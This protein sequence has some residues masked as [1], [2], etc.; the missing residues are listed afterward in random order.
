M[1]DRIENRS[2]FL[3]LGGGWIALL[4]MAL[5]GCNGDGL[6][7]ADT[8]Q[9]VPETRPEADLTVL[10][11]SQPPA[12]VADSVS[13][14]AVKGKN[15]FAEM[16]FADSLGHPAD[17]LLRFY[18]DGKSLYRYPDGKKFGSKDSVLITIRVTDPRTLAFEFE[19]SGLQF[20]DKEPAI[21]TVN[22][23]R[24]VTQPGPVSRHDDDDDDDDDD[25]EDD[26]DQ[27]SVIEAD[28]ALWVQE[29]LAADY[30]R[31]TTLVDTTAKQVIGEVP[32]F[33]KY[34][35]AY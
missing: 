11:I 22:Y 32:G 4:T 7:P 31:I 17:R 14:W 29:Q 12:L 9:S 34:A 10:T 15:R 25:V 21:L 8:P 23:A 27:S 3:M 20:K 26:D 33:S 35:V 16:F 2:P 28:L 18:V 24:A 1:S 13:F 19:P 5:L 30:S 6:A